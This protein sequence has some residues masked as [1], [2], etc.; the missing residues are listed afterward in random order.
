MFRNDIGKKNLYLLMNVIMRTTVAKIIVIG[1]WEYLFSCIIM[2]K[3][4][5]W[6]IICFTPILKSYIAYQLSLI[7]F[8]PAHQRVI[9]SIYISIFI[10]SVVNLLCLF[11]YQLHRNPIS[12]ELHPPL[13]SLIS[14]CGNSTNVCQNPKLR[15][16][17][18]TADNA[19]FVWIRLWA[20]NPDPN[21]A[22]C[23][24]SNVWWVGVALNWNAQSV[25]RHLQTLSS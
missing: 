25:G 15:F 24:V 14:S 8:Q 2:S 11:D 1:M 16:W 21:A 23:S 5:P 3:F 12:I 22:M 10:H 17:I 4:T 18:S 7:Y 13:V 9:D 19:Q 6:Q 20:Q